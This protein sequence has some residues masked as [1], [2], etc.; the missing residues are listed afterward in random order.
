MVHPAVPNSDTLVDLS[1]TVYSIYVDQG[2]LKF[3]GEDHISS[4]SWPI[5]SL[6]TMN[7]ALLHFF[8]VTC[9]WQWIT[10]TQRGTVAIG[11]KCFPWLW[12]DV[13]ARYVTLDDDVFIAQFGSA[14]SMR[15]VIELTVEDILKQATVFHT[16]DGAQPAQTSLPR[17]GGEVIWTGEIQDGGVGDMIPPRD[18]KNGAKASEMKSIEP[19]CC[20][21]EHSGCERC[22]PWSLVWLRG[23]DF[24]K[25]RHPA[26]CDFLGYVAFCQTNTFFVNILF[27]HYWQ[28]AFCSPVIWLRMSDFARGP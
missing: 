14:S 17:D 12:R 16:M 25:T 2:S 10:K 21:T 22:R 23:G 28:N 7:S 4:S 18:T 9:G 24:S 27:F 26:W 11:S 13:D 3:L 19:G 15:R 6:S 8:Y 20:I 5:P 1:T